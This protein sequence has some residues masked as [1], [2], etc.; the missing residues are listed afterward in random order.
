MASSQ[1]QTAR[2]SGD[3]TRQNNKG[4]AVSEYGDDSKVRYNLT[5]KLNAQKDESMSSSSINKTRHMM[6]KF[7]NDGGSDSRHS[8]STN[9]TYT[10]M[11]KQR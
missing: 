5:A 7:T 6:L 2:F 4:S 9:N 1:A 10:S 11:T 8:K 3:F